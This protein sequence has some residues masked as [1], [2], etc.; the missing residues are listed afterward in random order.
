MHMTYEY[1]MRGPR[2]KQLSVLTHHRE[3][4]SL[5]TEGREVSLSIPSA[6]VYTRSSSIPSTAVRFMSHTRHVSWNALAGR[7]AVSI[8]LM[9]SDGMHDERVKTT[10]QGIKMLASIPSVR[11]D[12]KTKKLKI[13]FSHIIKC[14]AS[15]F[16]ASRFIGWE[17]DNEQNTLSFK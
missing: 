13:K 16:H 4:Y 8:I 17:S 3:W 15:W 2:L 12:K 11:R 1:C 5:H 6:V 9:P 7:I 14:Q 10:V